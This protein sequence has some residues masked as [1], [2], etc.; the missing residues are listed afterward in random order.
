MVPTAP[1]RM[2]MSTP[3]TIKSV[4]KSAKIS[5]LN[6]TP[7][8]TRCTKKPSK[9]SASNY[10]G[11]ISTAERLRRQLC[12]L[13]GSSDKV[14]LG[15]A[16]HRMLDFK[17]MGTPI[18][19]G[20]KENG[21]SSG[22]EKINRRRIKALRNPH[23]EDSV[24]PLSPLALNSPIS[25]GFGRRQASTST[26]RSKL[27]FT[28]ENSSSK[29]PRSKGALTPTPIAS[30]A[31][32][33]K[34][35][36]D[37][38]PLKPEAANSI[39]DNAACV[40]PQNPKAK[41]RSDVKTSNKT[42]TRKQSIRDTLALLGPTLRKPVEDMLVLLHSKQRP[43]NTA[44]P[45]S[46][47]A[48][49]SDEQGFVQSWDARVKR[50]RAT[51]LKSSTQEETARGLFHLSMRFWDEQ[52]DLDSR[53]STHI[54][55]A[56]ELQ[57]TDDLLETLAEKLSESQSLSQG[58]R[59][60]LE[61]V[62]QTSANSL[63][64]R[65]DLSLH[66][67]YRWSTDSADLRIL[68]LLSDFPLARTAMLKCSACSDELKL[69]DVEDSA[70]EIGQKG[71]ESGL[72]ADVIRAL[73]LSFRG[74][75]ELRTTVEREEGRPVLDEK[76]GA[77]PDDVLG[78]ELPVMQ[79]LHTLAQFLHDDSRPQKLV[80]TRRDAHL[81]SDVAALSVQH[82]IF[83]AFAFAFSPSDYMH[84]NKDHKLNPFWIHVVEC[85]QAA[86]AR[87]KAGDGKRGTKGDLWRAAC[88]MV[89]PEQN[90]PFW[91]SM[92]NAFQFAVK[93][94]HRELVEAL[95]SFVEAFSAVGASVIE[96]GLSPH[97]SSSSSSSSSSKLDTHA[98][99]NEDASVAGL[100]QDG[101]EDDV[102]G[103]CDISDAELSI[104]LD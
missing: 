62:I 36:A 92:K 45:E 100:L 17:P 103:E 52:C 76:S 71:G 68:Y 4:A 90:H 89:P 51:V 69:V 40:L 23:S 39:I 86:T 41:T 82:N 14:V 85:A 5:V 96:F 75:R 44:W 98:V 24:V 43:D 11:E 74:L 32:L 72:L 91:E 60:V 9:T 3:T 8:R 102:V 26:G 33:K 94:N 57:E 104:E 13:S 2:D 10:N 46:K 31:Q 83:E 7:V 65:L 1:L 101:E 48:L 97:S 15:N 87:A 12:R 78:F 16:T 35:W 25:T 50:M 95:M 63:R 79:C 61:E 49:T 47:P 64:T 30:S 93:S 56:E 19:I 29:A 21:S 6:A 66:K 42:T 73:D 67:P 34:P 37:A 28:A 81:L 55:K 59:E 22:G 20:D 80:P 38:V 84:P 77:D 58:V 88:Y 53:L 54:A 70:E 27:I 18:R 99:A